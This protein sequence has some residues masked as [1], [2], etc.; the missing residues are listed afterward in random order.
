MHSFKIAASMAFL[1]SLVAAAPK[2]ALDKRATGPSCTDS[3]FISAIVDTH[4]AHRKYHQV[5]N[6][7]WDS[8]LADFANSAANECK[9]DH[10]VSP[11]P[12]TTVP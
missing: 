2:F 9:F 8:T 1:A 5:G 6:L 11:L 3:D 10:T 4:N 12:S 7:E